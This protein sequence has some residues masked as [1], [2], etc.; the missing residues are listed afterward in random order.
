VN[1]QLGLVNQYLFNLQL[2]W[3]WPELWLNWNRFPI[4]SRLGWMLRK[5]NG[6]SQPLLWAVEH[7]QA[8]KHCKTTAHTQSDSFMCCIV[9][10]MRALEAIRTAYIQKAYNLRS[11]LDSFGISYWSQG[12]KESLKLC[13]TFWAAVCVDRQ[14]LPMKDKAPLQASRGFGPRSNTLHVPGVL[15]VL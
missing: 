4:R 8:D 11:K 13:S 5:Q 14:E 10:H 12:V 15:L 3:W 7:L 1:S 6:I 2:L 9:P